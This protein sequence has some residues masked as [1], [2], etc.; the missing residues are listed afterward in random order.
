MF[1]LCDS[2]FGSDEMRNGGLESV[3]EP[4]PRQLT[5]LEQALLALNSQA[6]YIPLRV[7][8]GFKPAISAMGNL[9][10]SYAE[11][12]VPRQV[13]VTWRRACAVNAIIYIALVLMVGVPV[14]CVIALAG[15]HSG[16]F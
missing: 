13:L 8:R 16:L 1:F 14:A 2:N 9:V 6:G 7:R 5:L 15:L 11:R 3:F 10:L 12:Y 4:E